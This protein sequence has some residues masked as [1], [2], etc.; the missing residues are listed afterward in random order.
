VR[1]VERLVGAAVQPLGLTQ[2][3]TVDEAGNRVAKFRMTQDLSFSADR[4]GPDISIN[5]RIDMGA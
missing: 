5:N 2:Q 4:V 1:T 3:W